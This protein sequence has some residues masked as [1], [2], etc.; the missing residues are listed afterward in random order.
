[1]FDGVTIGGAIMAVVIF[2]IVL[3][4]FLLL[5]P[6]AKKESE[7]RPNFNPDDF[8]VSQDFTDPGDETNF[9]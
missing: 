5:V 6:Y 3:I 1:M 8:K 7:S 9:W 2:L 4:P